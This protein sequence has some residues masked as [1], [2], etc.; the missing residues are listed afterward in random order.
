LTTARREFKLAFLQKCA[1]DGRTPAE[2]L[3]IAKLA[4]ANLEKRA[5]GLDSVTGPLSSALQLGTEVVKP[6]GSL[7]LMAAIMGPPALGLAG[8]VGL[9]KLQ[10]VDDTDVEGLRKR[11][12]I[13][14][15]RLQA[16]RLRDRMKDRA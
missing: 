5:F 8:G 11:R 9:A 12:L 10:D 13:E 3:G 16:Q 7:G 2:T 15:Y 4:V 1:E 14:E 6:I